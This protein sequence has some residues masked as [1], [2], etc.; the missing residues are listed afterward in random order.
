MN[1][2]L[3]FFSPLRNLTWVVWDQGALVYA[4]IEEEAPSAGTSVNFR[5]V[6]LSYECLFRWRK[7]EEEGSFKK[8]FRSVVSLTSL[9]ERASGRDGCTWRTAPP[10]P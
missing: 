10:Y 1:R 6:E 3:S 9:I 7:F 5:I 8:R 2:S 4:R